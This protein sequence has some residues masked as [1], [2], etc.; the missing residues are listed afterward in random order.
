[1]SNYETN[2]VTGCFPDTVCVSKKVQA[3][4]FDNQVDRVNNES[5]KLFL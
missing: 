3:S 2:L 4:I 5:C 1:M